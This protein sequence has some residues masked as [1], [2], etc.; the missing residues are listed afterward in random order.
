MGAGS[1]VAAKLAGQI[2]SIMETQ[3]DP[4]VGSPT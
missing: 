1:V 4:R 2:I 3:M